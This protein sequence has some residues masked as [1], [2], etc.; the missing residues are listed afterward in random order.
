MTSFAAAGR[1]AS[2]VVATNAV[3]QVMRPGIF[4]DISSGF[5]PDLNLPTLLT[6][7]C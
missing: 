5:I 6:D 7:H 3:K 2:A 4:V 1:L